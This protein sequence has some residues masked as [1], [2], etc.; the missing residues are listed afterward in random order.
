MKNDS[1]YI[2]NDEVNKNFID[3][4]I[5]KFKRLIN[6]NKKSRKSS[7]KE[8]LSLEEAKKEFNEIK[9]R[10]EKLESYED[11]LLK[12][13]DE[14]MDMDYC[15]V[16][17][18]D[19]N[20]MINCKQ[21][22]LGKRFIKYDSVNIDSKAL[23]VLMFFDKESIIKIEEVINK[24]DKNELNIEKTYKVSNFT[25]K[26]LCEL[27]ISFE[28]GKYQIKN[29]TPYNKEILGT[30][31]QITN[32]YEEYHLQ[33]KEIRERFLKAFSDAKYELN[34]GSPWMNN[35]VVNDNLIAMM[36]AL[37][38]RGGII[39]IIYG[40]AENS[41]IVNT[42]KDNYKN[43]NSDKIAEKLMETFSDYGASFKIKKVNSHNKLLICDEKYYMETSF[44][45]LSFSGEYDENSKDIRDEGATYSSNIEVIKDLRNR[46]FNF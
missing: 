16:T 37:L 26:N 34:I 36:E 42:K 15:V 45:L 39:K 2:E 31:N 24:L 18:N 44:N 8:A 41:S 20:S 32:N 3:K 22:T 6:F 27:E 21:D 4:Y 14:I 38:K 17:S 1:V 9:A 5:N 46:Y 29:I 12:Y 11:E 40:I 43:R 13:D 28:D 33:N 23:K 35:Y 30:L 19:L 10:K 7:K 25:V